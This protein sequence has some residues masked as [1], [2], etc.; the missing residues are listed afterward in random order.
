MARDILIVED[1]TDALANYGNRIRLALGIEPFLAADARQALNI[2]RLYSVKVVV[3]DQDMG[4]NQMSGTQ[5]IKAIREELG[6]AIPCIL[7]TGYADKV[8]VREAINLGVSRFIDKDDATKLPDE[9]QG[10][11]SRYDKDLSTQ[12][13]VEINSL[14]FEEKKFVRFN[15]GV[16]VHLVRIALIEDYMPEGAWRTDYRAERGITITR[17][18]TIEHK[19]RSSLELET[20]RELTSS[21]AAKLSQGP[22]GLESSLESR[23]RESIRQGLEREL[24]VT[25]KETVDVKD[26]AN[27]PGN[28]GIR[29]R[30]YQSA[31]MFKRIHLLLRVDCDCC[32]SDRSIRATLDAPTD[33]IAKRVVEYYDH[34]PELAYY[35]G[36]LSATFESSPSSKTGT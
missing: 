15:A 19:V 30:E 12:T 35:T 32:G 25:A 17:E 4:A 13:A 24:V 29:V 34:S 7:F 5:L 8:D 21:I 14:L 33:R 18:Q 16:K 10:A 6:L 9:I 28:V 31:P 26:L 2:L 3:T 23:L 20:D 22:A 27:E 11:I 36:F 1:K